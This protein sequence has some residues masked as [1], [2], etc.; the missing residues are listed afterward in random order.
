[1]Q[2]ILPPKEFVL[3]ILSCVGWA[4][5]NFKIDKHTETKILHPKEFIFTR[6]DLSQS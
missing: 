6:I 5:A 2:E 3:F 1:M 4:L